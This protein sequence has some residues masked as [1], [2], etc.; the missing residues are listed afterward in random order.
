[1]PPR[2]TP[3]APRSVRVRMYRHGLGDCFLLSFPGLKR[4]ELFHILIDCGLISVATN[5]KEK[6]TAV[7]R[8]IQKTTGNRLD[9][10]VLTHQHWDHVSGFA[11]EQAQAVFAEMNIR[12]VW[13]AWTEDPTNELGQRLRREREAKVRALHQ[14]AIALRGARLQGADVSP[15]LLERIEAQLSF[16][17]LEHA[18][19]TP[20]AA[21]K[22][23][24]TSK[25]ER[26]FQFPATRPQAAVRF[27]H[28]TDPPHE[29]PELPGVR[30]YVLG[31]PEN[32]GLLKRSDPTAKGREVYE[33]A[34]DASFAE[35]LAAGFARLAAAEDADTQPTSDL[36]FDA[37][38]RQQPEK[39]AA[40]K[41]LLDATWDAPGQEWRKIDTD[42][43][44]AAES[45]ALALDKHTNNTSLALAFEFTGS[46]KV[47]LFP[48]D[49]QVGN[50]LS[51]QD[52]EWKFRAGDSEQVVKAPN[53]LSR[54]VFYKVGHHGSHNATLRDKGLELMNHPDLVAF[55][56]VSVAEAQKNRWFEM[57]FSKLLQRLKQKTRG[58][59][60]L[61]DPDSP[62]P[63]DEDLAA[64]NLPE[65]R[66]FRR[67][68]K[69]DPAGLYYDF[70]VSAK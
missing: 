47:L 42:W 10:V 65:K 14:A 17:G 69:P 13:Q 15:G 31:P 27:C 34:M 18:S 59:V 48:G 36:P 49:A 51:W 52:L 35:H 9:L 60:V 44:T 29:L 19:E 46:G 66:A 5:P 2:P 16:F 62:P 45:I 21:A 63:S 22:D 43:A 57:P 7:A 70:T 11:A 6:M 12:R 67:A 55:I 50:W 3:R 20:L 23:R 54:T 28:P 56:P 58:R 38:L 40:L 25:V 41:K 37:Y 33:F 30:I 26:A 39:S 24:T 4:G 68:L 61:S 64:L 53:L 32:E 1:M 8:D